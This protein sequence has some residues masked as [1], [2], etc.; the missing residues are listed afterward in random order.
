ARVTYLRCQDERKAVYDALND[1]KSLS[2]ITGGSGKGYRIHDLVN[3][4]AQAQL[5]DAELQDIAEHAASIVT[6]SLNLDSDARAS[7]EWEYERKIMSQIDRCYDIFQ[8]R[9]AR[10]DDDSTMDN[11]TREI[12]CKL[13]KV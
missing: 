1:L 11:Q 4:W 5:K 12:A 8:N 6:S 10:D 13:A 7:H 9:L 3:Q 2:F